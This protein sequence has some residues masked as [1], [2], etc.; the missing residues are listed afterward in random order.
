MTMTKIELRA[1]EYRTRAKD[2]FAAAE[3]SPLDR[4]RE[5]LEQAGARWTELA[6]HEERRAREHA[7]LAAKEPS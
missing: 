6:E 2:A 7:A 1:S 5:Q 4:A 3:A